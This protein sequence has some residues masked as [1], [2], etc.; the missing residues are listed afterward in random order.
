[1]KIKSIFKAICF[2]LKAKKLWVK[3]P[4]TQIL[5]YDRT[6]SEVFL[7]YLKKHTVHIL[8]NRGE[9][10][11][12]YVLL[13]LILKYGLKVNFEKYYAEYTQ[14]VAPKVIITFIDNTIT[15]YKLKKYYEKGF[16]ISV[17]NGLRVDF[18]EYL[19]SQINESEKLKADAIF[20]FGTAI[21]KKYSQYILSEVYP[22][23]SILSNKHSIDTANKSNT[24]IL[25]ISQYRPPIVINGIP[26]MPVGDRHIKWEDFYSTESILLPRLKTLCQLN[27]YSLCICGNSFN[28]NNQEEEYYKSLLGGDGWVYK[29]KN[30][31]SDSYSKLDKPAI[32]A[33]IDSTL[34]F[35]ALGRGLKSMIF[36]GRG[37]TLK[38]VD[39]N[40]GWPDKLSNQ[41]FFW[42]NEVNI[43]EIDRIFDNVT[44]CDHKQWTKSSKD[45]IPSVMKF[46]KNNSTLINLIEKNI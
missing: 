23:G 1:M 21:A 12:L 10:F 8:E 46:D 20:C 7:D 36:T 22:C 15:F 41:G 16:F 29:E 34:G 14:L 37:S 5:I 43:S 44:L 4:K 27:G 25:Y 11:N 9:S 31:S 32:I 39:R 19:E 24:E 35:E 18:W 28:K 17:Q 2:V 13:K 6:G 33:F 40:L 45:I 26:G 38:T 30:Y 42:T 3:P